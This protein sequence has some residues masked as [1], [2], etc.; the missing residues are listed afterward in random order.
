VKVKKITV[1]LAVLAMAMP[2]VACP[3]TWQENESGVIGKFFGSNVDASLTLEISYADNTDIGNVDYFTRNWY[4]D[5]DSQIADLLLQANKDINVKVS[6]EGVDWF[7]RYGVDFLVWDGQGTG[8]Q[9][10]KT[11]GWEDYWTEDGSKSFTMNYDGQCLTIDGVRYTVDNNFFDI[12]AQANNTKGGK[13]GIGARL[14]FTPAAVPAPG[15]MLLGSIGVA[16]VGIL[17]QRKNL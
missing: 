15:A 5:S 4:G 16:V 3:T 1:V 13:L 17:R 8:A 6:W 9:A 11:Y 14:D 2:V 12:F 7:P 10:D